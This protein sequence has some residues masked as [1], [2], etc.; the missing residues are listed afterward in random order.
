MAKLLPQQY[1]KVLFHLTDGIEEHE[2]DKA[3]DT[4]IA[5]LK[6]EHVMK[7]LPYI[8][9]YFEQY[10]KEKRGVHEIEVTSAHPLSKQ[11]IDMI[12]GVVGENVETKTKVDETLVGGIVIRTKNTILDGSVKTQLARLKNKME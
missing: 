6:K 3:M 2:L 1:A 12:E 11:A 7:K 10:E 4:F 5:F 8:L 9:K